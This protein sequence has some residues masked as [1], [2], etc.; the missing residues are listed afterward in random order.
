MLRPLTKLRARPARKAFLVFAVVLLPSLVALSPAG[1][2]GFALYARPFTQSSPSQSAAAE[3]ELQTGIALTRTGRFAEAIPHFLAARRQVADEFAA[4]FNLALCY[5]AVGQNQAAVP[6][7]Q[8]LITTGQATAAVYNLLTQALIGASRIDEANQSFER[9][10]SLDPNNEKLYLLIADSCMD[11]E[12]Y[13]FG[14]KVVSTGLQHLPKSA[15]LHYERGV[16]LSFLDQP[17][18]ARKDLQAA[19]ELASGTPL[20][21]LAQAQEGLLTADMTKTTAAARAGLRKDPA[22]YVL[23]AIL[24]Q[25]LIREGAAPGQAEFAEARSALEKSVSIR[26][27]YSVSQL[28]LGQLE[29]LGGQ[30]DAALEHLTKAQQLAPD[31]PAVY[32]QL[33]AACRRRGNLKEA[34]RNLAVL[35]GLN[36]RQAAKYKLDPPDHKGSYIGSLSKTD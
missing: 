3:A 35:A 33:A 27:E 36:R 30:T 22:N 11:H 26:P 10:A 15:R 6:V 2:N 18:A 32:S 4:D 14:V 25:A 29:L 12:S 20:A 19:S 34:E 24:G 13:D 8:S 16:L 5:V 7:L 31:N 28:A 1:E 9:A 23:L 17:D 21:F